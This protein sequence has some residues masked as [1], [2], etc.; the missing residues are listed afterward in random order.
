[1]TQMN[2]SVKQTQTHRLRELTCGCQEGGAGEEEDGKV[3]ISRC[4]LVNMGFSSSSAGKE[5]GC[6]AKDTGDEG[7]IPGPGRSPGKGN[8]NPLGILA[9]EIPW[10]EESGRLWSMRSQRVTHD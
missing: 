5:S 3:G 2:L 9:W 10:T 4:K 8:G 1:M 7:S 6:N